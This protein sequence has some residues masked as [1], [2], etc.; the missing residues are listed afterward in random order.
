M[1]RM[2]RNLTVLGVIGSALIVTTCFLIFHFR[3]PDKTVL[4]RLTPGMKQTE[5]E[6]LL[7]APARVTGVKATEE[8]AWIYEDFFSA[9]SVVVVFSKDGSLVNVINR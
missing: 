6:S 4:S 5:I 7:G 8:T 3:V 9:E 2:T 1:K